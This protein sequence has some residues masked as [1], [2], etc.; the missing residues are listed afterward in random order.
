MVLASCWYHLRFSFSDISDIYLILQEYA[1]SV[2]NNQG[3]EAEGFIFCSRS[4][5]CNSTTTWSLHGFDFSDDALLSQSLFTW[6]FQICLVFSSTKPFPLGFPAF[7]SWLHQ[8][9]H[10]KRLVVSD[11][12]SLWKQVS[13][14][15]STFQHMICHSKERSLTD[16]FDQGRYNCKKS[17]KWIVTAWRCFFTAVIPLLWDSTL[18]K[19]QRHLKK[20]W[21]DISSIGSVP[22]FFSSSSVCHP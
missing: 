13:F 3:K 5:P 2:K 22:V 9:R 4:V 8:K 12:W 19:G 17:A 16:A 18:C 15:Q 11:H 1:W 7:S 6:L 20:P 21:D 10:L 14:L